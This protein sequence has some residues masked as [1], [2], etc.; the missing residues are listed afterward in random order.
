MGSAEDMCVYVCVCERASV[1]VCDVMIFVS[2]LVVS[3]KALASLLRLVWARN[4]FARRPNFS[5]RTVPRRSSAEACGA[6]PHWQH[7]RGIASP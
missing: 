2:A 1:C 7:P 4:G 6:W 5:D 3:S